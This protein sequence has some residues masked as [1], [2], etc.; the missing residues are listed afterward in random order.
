[1]ANMA[2]PVGATV[3]MLAVRRL[4]VAVLGQ[5]LAARSAAV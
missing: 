2:D 3:A 4:S 1:M 5:Y